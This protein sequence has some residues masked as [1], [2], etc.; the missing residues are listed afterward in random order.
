MDENKQME[1]DETPG[2]RRKG[3]KRI[4]EKKRSWQ[5]ELLSW[6]LTIGVPVLIVLLLNQFV[7]KLVVVSGTSMYPTLYDRD[8][9]IVRTINYTPSQGDIVICHTSED[10]ELESKNIVKRVIAVGG[11]TVEINYEANTVT[12]DGVVLDEP[13]LNTSYGDVMMSGYY[14]DATYVVPEGY[15]FVMGDNRNNSTDSRSHAVGMVPLEDVIGVSLIDIPLGH[16]IGDSSD[17]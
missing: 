13:Y 5:R 8:L 10:S 9:L 14:E 15:I 7:G 12:V 6:I 17:P 4:R 11:Q 16:L 1:P 3:G 2:K